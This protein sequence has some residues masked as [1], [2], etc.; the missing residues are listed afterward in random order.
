MERGGREIP[1]VPAVVGAAPPA[2]QLGCFQPGE[3]AHRHGTVTW[4]DTGSLQPGRPKAGSELLLQPGSLIPRHPR[5]RNV[6]P[7]LIQATEVLMYPRGL[8]LH[9]LGPCLRQQL[10]RQTCLPISSM[11]RGTLLLQLCVC[12]SV[13][14]LSEQLYLGLTSLWRSKGE[15]GGKLG[16]EDG[17]G[18]MS[19]E[20]ANSPWLVQNHFLR[21]PLHS[22][23]PVLLFQSEC[24]L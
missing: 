7:M 11:H 13:L 24:H 19:G 3:V 22:M 21:S 10:C 1:V 4:E 8:H 23:L 17:R 16:R 2:S 5:V 12:T 14:V 18:E 6:I 9:C 20:G 15:R